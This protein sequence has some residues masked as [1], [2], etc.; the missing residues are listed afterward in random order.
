MKIVFK[1]DHYKIVKTKF[2][3]KTVF[4]LRDIHTDRLIMDYTENQIE[5]SKRY[6]RWLEKVRPLYEIG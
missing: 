2:K 1:S 5:E 3:K 6:A 4:E